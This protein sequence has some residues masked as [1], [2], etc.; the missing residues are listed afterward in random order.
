[1]RERMLRQHLYSLKNEKASKR[2]LDMFRKRKPEEEMASLAML[3]E[4]IQS[5]LAQGK[6]SKNE[7]LK[8]MSYA[9]T[10]HGN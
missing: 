3:R 9:E 1:M 2:W 10:L 4:V 5:M 6:I 7:G 8:L